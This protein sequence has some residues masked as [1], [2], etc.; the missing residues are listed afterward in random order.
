MPEMGKEPHGEGVLDRARGFQGPGTQEAGKRRHR[1]GMT[2]APL[3]R[4]P[5]SFIGSM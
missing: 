5:L 1:T 3:T 2:Q 4:P